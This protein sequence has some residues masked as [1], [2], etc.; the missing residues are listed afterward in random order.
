VAADIASLE[1]NKNPFTPARRRT[2]GIPTP[3]VSEP[4]PENTP[5]Q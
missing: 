5:A 1:G 2:L 3:P 4:V